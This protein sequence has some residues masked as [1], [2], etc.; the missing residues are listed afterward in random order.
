MNWQVTI[1]AGLYALLGIAGFLPGV[2]L[3]LMLVTVPPFWYFVL[4]TANTPVSLENLLEGAS[5]ATLDASAD[6]PFGPVGLG[7]LAL[8]C[9]LAV[10]SLTRGIALLRGKPGARKPVLRLGVLYLFAFPVGTAL[11]AWTIWAL[12]QPET[13]DPRPKKDLPSQADRMAASLCYGI[14]VVYALIVFY[15]MYV[16]SRA[17]SSA[18]LRVH[19]IQSLAVWAVLMLAGQVA[20]L[21]Q[22]LTVV[23]L[24]PFVGVAALLAIL[25]MA[26]LANGGMLF[27]LPWVGDFAERWQGSVAAFVDQQADQSQDRRTL[28]IH[29][30]NLLQGSAGPPKDVLP[31]IDGI[32]GLHGFEQRI[33]QRNDP[34]PGVVYWFVGAIAVILVL[35]IVWK[36]ASSVASSGWSNVTSGPAIFAFVIFGGFASFLLYVVFRNVIVHKFNTGEFVVARWPLRLG[37]QSRVR[38]VGRSRKGAKVE[39]LSASLKCME[40]IR[41]HDNDRGGGIGGVVAQNIAMPQATPLVTADG[42]VAAEWTIRVPRDAPP[43]F[44]SRGGGIAWQ[45]VVEMR[46]QGAPDSTHS[47]ELLVLPEVAES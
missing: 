45:F 34:T 30:K 26:T 27:K 29:R 20:E 47:F 37:G 33:D 31:R 18:F 36:V 40:T 2:M 28:E 39:Q 32:P 10:P 38:Y 41:W 7:L 1:I 3:L 19:A 9:L 15:S 6:F 35:V 16:S 46:I 43:S 17:R 21:V 25:L 4:R 14:P 24:P 8:H 42:S 11:G 12:T 23:A 44:V 22:P 5:S 13:V